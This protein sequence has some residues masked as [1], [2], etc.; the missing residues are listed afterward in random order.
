MRPES[1]I[2]CENAIRNPF[3]LLFLGQVGVRH[4]VESSTIDYDA[5]HSSLHHN[6]HTRSLLPP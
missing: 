4:C 1:I 5:V 3:P 6:I 2:G